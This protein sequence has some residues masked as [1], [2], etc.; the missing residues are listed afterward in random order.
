MRD[1]IRFPVLCKYRELHRSHANLLPR[2]PRP[3]SSHTRSE[4]RLHDARND[5]EHVEVELQR[6][7]AAAFRVLSDEAAKLRSEAAIDDP[8]AVRRRWRS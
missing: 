4:V 8:S 7:A 5:A 6:L 2:D 1:A 3:A